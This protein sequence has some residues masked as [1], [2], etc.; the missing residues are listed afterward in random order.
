MDNSSVYVGRIDFGPIDPSD[1]SDDLT[2]D[3]RFGW[4]ADDGILMICKRGAIVNGASIPR[5]LWP[6]L[7]HPLSRR[8]R[9]WSVPHDCGYN[10]S[11][12]YINTKSH[13]IS[14]LKP[15]ALIEFC[16]KL[17][18]DL[19][20]ARPSR[21]WHDLQMVRAM[22]ATGEGKFKRSVCFLGV[23]AGGWLPWKS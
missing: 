6:L 3:T 15:D 23:R 12:C 1:P 13:V 2:L 16:D 4:L 7:G 9:I 19:H 21:L 5:A 14:R 11:A 17:P 18:E 22:K 10:G 20:V 8:N